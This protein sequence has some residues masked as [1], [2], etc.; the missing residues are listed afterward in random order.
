MYRIHSIPNYIVLIAWFIISG[1]AH[2]VISETDTITVET[3]R[4]RARQNELQRVEKTEQTQQQVHKRESWSKRAENVHAQLTNTQEKALSY[5]RRLDQLLYSDEGKCIARHGNN[6]NTFIIL[7]LYPV[8][9]P[10]Q[11]QQKIDEATAYINQI[12]TASQG[13]EVGYFPSE[14]I[15]KGIETLEAWS[16]TKLKAL[17]EDVSTLSKI[18]RSTPQDIDLENSDT[19]AAAL[20]KELARRKE[21]HATGRALGIEIAKTE[22]IEEHQKAARVAEVEHASTTS[23]VMLSE[24]RQR[25]DQLQRESDIRIMKLDEEIR[26]KH[27]HAQE[28]HKDSMSDLKDERKSRQ[29]ARSIR[30]NDAE[31][32]LQ[33]KRDEEKRRALE[34]KARTYRVQ[35][36]LKPF[37]A[38]SYHQY[39][40]PAGSYDKQPVSLNRLSNL[41]ALKREV[42]GLTI[43]NQVATDSQDKSRSRWPFGMYYITLNDHEKDYVKEA[44][45]YLIE[46]GETLVELG[47]LAR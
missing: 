32:E 45:G 21:W 2:A 28:D 3:V 16:A 38:R 46:L 20:E 10:T 5:F 41:G 40:M 14:E 31:R 23:K 39:R 6:F 13:P 35:E 22:V 17:E 9:N 29:L 7:K 25:N 12:K 15:R 18:L 42:Y 27:T 44:Q 4:E 8:F 34:A 37:I 1:S 19:L 47:Y 33:K 24:E 30:H 36:V 11:I 43:L 26:T